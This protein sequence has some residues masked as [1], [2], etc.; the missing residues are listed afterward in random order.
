MSHTCLPTRRSNYFEKR[1][2]EC[3]KEMKALFEKDRERA[4]RDGYQ[5]GLY[6]GG[7]GSGYDE[8]VAFVKWKAKQ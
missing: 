2:A 4:F 8:D 7:G 6:D 5:A 3:A 1:C